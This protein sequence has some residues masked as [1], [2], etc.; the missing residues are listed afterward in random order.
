M[1]SHVIP[2]F[3]MHTELAGTGLLWTQPTTL[4]NEML[5]PDLAVD[6]TARGRK[7]H[8]NCLMLVLC[9]VCAKTKFTMAEY[10]LCVHVWILLNCYILPPLG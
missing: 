9:F 6:L 8:N 7:P 10:I 4:L 3:V 5:M 2:N 1:T